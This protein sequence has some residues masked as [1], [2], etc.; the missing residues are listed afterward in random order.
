M[1]QFD[2]WRPGLGLGHKSLHDLRCQIFVGKGKKIL[3][4]VFHSH[5]RDSQV[6]NLCAKSKR[7]ERV[8]ER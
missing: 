4:R 2:M 5:L 6:S 3:E 1:K 8:N 7:Q